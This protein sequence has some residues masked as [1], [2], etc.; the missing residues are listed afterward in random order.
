L[1]KANNSQIGD[2]GMGQCPKCGKELAEGIDCDCGVSAG[3]W[4]GGYDNAAIG[5]YASMKNRMGIGVPERNAT[6]VYERGMNIVPECIGA[7]EGEFPVKQYDI[8]VLRNL[9]KLERAE[10]RMQVTNKRVLFRA[11]GRSVGGRTALQHEFSIA[12]VS[13][14]E[15][16]RDYK[17]SI[18]YL[19][20]AFIILNLSSVIISGAASVFS[21]H[22]SPLYDIRPASE[23]MMSPPHIMRVREAQME[24]TGQR[25]EAEAALTLAANAKKTAE[26]REQQAISERVAAE[27]K[28]AANPGGACWNEWY[29]GVR[30]DKEH[31]KKQT[32]AAQK[33]EAAATAARASA[34]MVERQAAAQR[35]TFVEKE[36]AAIKKRVSA[37]KTWAVLMMLFGLALGFG[38][39]APFFLLYK[40]FGLKLFAL[41]F[42]SFG[43]LL[44][45]EVYSNAI[46]SILLA[47][48]LIATVVCV[49]IYCFRPN[50]VIGIKNRMGAAEPVNI[51][52]GRRIGFSEVIPTEETERAIREMGA[53]IGD[54]QK[55]GDGGAKKWS[56]GGDAPAAPGSSFVAASPQRVAP[57]SRPSW[58]FP[59]VSKKHI[60]IAA[61]VAAVCVI[62]IAAASI[63]R[64]NMHK[65]FFNSGM[66]CIAKENYAGAV[67]YFSKAIKSNSNED[68]NYYYQRGVAYFKREDYAKAVMDYTEAIRLDPQKVSYYSERAGANLALKDY[69]SAIADFSEALRLDPNNASYYSDKAEASVAMKDYR[70]AVADYTQAIRLAQSE[71]KYYNSRG[72][73]YR[74]LESY[75][76]AIADH[77]AAIRINPN[78]ARYHNNRGVAYLLKKDYDNAIANYTEA[79]QRAPN[80]AKYY[81]NRGSAY[82][83]KK[84]FGNAA[85]DFEEAVRLDPNNEE[86]RKN[87][88]NASKNVASAAK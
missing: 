42:S 47:I 70:K 80:E 12:D 79:I 30:C 27:K 35:D 66:A 10:G 26:D 34:D 19:I 40:K 37:E 21:G 69:N 81:N 32:L 83:Y 49:F 3:A 45:N 4:D 5:F 43:F 76:D 44:C 33:K 6:D 38:G 28:E 78:D 20:F 14:I 88:E 23:N 13:G 74:M 64:A 16:R 41:N 18:L 60:I 71:A 11:A 22:G 67:E 17:F 86:Y 85:A 1:D 9:L 65:R 48:T 62:G 24:A 63:V 52:S 75:D 29:Y 57:P 46:F 58:K 73:V 59:A 7:N 55:M 15:A 56:T 72:N 25:Q 36:K 8:A 61:A 39:L 2:D 54:I 68:A 50:L 87:F 53:I 51:R 84:D 31:Y 82:N 77:A